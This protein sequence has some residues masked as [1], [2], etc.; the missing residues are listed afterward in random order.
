MSNTRLHSPTLAETAHSVGPIQSLRG[1]MAG[2]TALAVAVSLILGAALPVNADRHKAV[3]AQ[4]LL[5]TTDD[6][7]ACAFHP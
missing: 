6:A 5:T 3:C 2:L 7:K 4:P 1:L